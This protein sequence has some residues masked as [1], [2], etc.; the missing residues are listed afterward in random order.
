MSL[1]FAIFFV[2]LPLF[3]SGAIKSTPRFDSHPPGKGGNRPPPPGL[4]G[5]HFPYP[6]HAGAP[7]EYLMEVSEKAR[8]EH[9]QLLS[10]ME[11]KPKA[12]L[13]EELAKWAEKSGI[14]VCI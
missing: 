2:L 10:E 7:P 11:E 12:Q 1:K 5:P 6:P 14:K 9:F 4:G 3:H 8:N 13:K